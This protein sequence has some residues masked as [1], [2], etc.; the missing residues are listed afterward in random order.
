[1]SILSDPIIQ[2]IWIMLLLPP[3]AA[4]SSGSEL[5]AVDET[6]RVALSERDVAGGVLVEQGIEEQEAAL[7]DRRGMRHQR[8]LAEAPRA[9]VAVEHFFEHVLAARGLRLDDPSGLEPDRDAVDQRALIG[10]RLGADDMAID[11]ARVRG[12]EHLFGR[13]VRIAGD[14]VLRR[15]CAPLPLMPV[16][17]PDRQIRARARNNAGRESVPR[18]SAMLRPAGKSGIVLG[19]GRDR[20]VAHRRARRRRS[21]PRACRPR[22]RRSSPGKTRFAQERVG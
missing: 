15:R 10:E 3:R 1:M 14:A 13:D 7:R 5:V 19:P 11:P 20:I 18:R 12:R 16:G 6:L 22:R 8:D 9:V 17:E 4:I 2:S 21:P